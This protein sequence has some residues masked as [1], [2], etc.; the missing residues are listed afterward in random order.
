MEEY[1]IVCLTETWL[2]CNIS[3]SEIFNNNYNI[4]RKDRYEDSMN[5]GG[6]VLI[7]IKSTFS[8]KFIDLQDNSVEQI[9]VMVKI[10]YIGNIYLFLS[11][12]PPQS[13]LDIYKTHLENISDISN[14]SSQTDYIMVLGDFNLGNINWCWSEDV[15]R[16][17]A[18]GLNLECEYLLTDCLFSLNL[19]QINDIKNSIGRI[20]DLVFVSTNINV[21]ISK[22]DR[23]L[24]R[25]S[26]HHVALEVNLSVY[27]YVEENEISFRRNFRK[28]DYDGLNN[29]LNAIEW[30][31]IFP[32]EELSAIYRV[33]TDII[34]PAIDKFVPLEKI[35]RNYNVPWCN[36]H[37]KSLKNARNKAYIKY[38]NSNSETNKT[39]FFRIRKEYEF[40]NKY[41]YGQYLAHAERNIKCNSK[42]FWNFVN[43]KRKKS[44][45]PNNLKFNDESYN[46]LQ[47]IC[48]GF[49]SYFNTV[50]DEPDP[51][52]AVLE[53]NIITPNVDQSEN[54]YS[55][56]YEMNPR[57]TL[58]SQRSFIARDNTLQEVTPRVNLGNQRTF[59][60]ITP[61]DVDIALRDLDITLQAGP[62]C[63][64]NIF[65]K[66][67]KQSLSL[68]LSI[69]FNKSLCE[70]VFLDQWKESYLSPIHKKGPK[71][72]VENYR[73]IAKLS[74]IP[75]IFE[76][77]VKDKIYV[78]ISRSITP[79]QHG[80]LSGKST[81]TNLVSYTKYVMDSIE[82]GYQVDVVYTDF[83]KA[84]DKVDHNILI[85][86]LGNLGFPSNFMN[87]IHTY[88]VGR[89]QRVKINESVSRSVV[90][91]TS[92]VPQ[93]SHLGPLFFLVFIN[94]IVSRFKFARVWQY[95][96]DMKIALK[97]KNI[98]DC[99]H[100]QSDLKELEQ[101]CQ[102][103]RLNLNVGKC[104]ILSA[105]RTRT[106]LSYEYSLHSEILER[107][108]EITDLGVVFDRKFSFNSHID[109]IV[110]KASINTGFV[111]HYAR[112]FR[113]PHVYKILFTAYVRS[114][115]EYGSIVWDPYYT[116]HS[117]R[118]ERVQRRYTRFIFYQI[119]HRVKPEYNVRCALLGLQTL[120]YRRTFL[121]AMF[122]R[123]LFSSSILCDE[124]RSFFI[125]RDTSYNLRR[126]N[127]LLE[128]LH[129]T[130]YG[131][132]EPITRLIILYNCC[133]DLVNFECSSKLSFKHAYFNKFPY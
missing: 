52:R 110:S 35:T 40:L 66:H 43:S 104:K 96:D 14:K 99:I 80:F 74:A 65:L 49:A 77:I 69:I 12:I 117:D 124:I 118:L 127:L 75:K 11:Y 36:H 132:N 46:D 84:F 125:M 83:S 13:A 68:A 28:A 89:I 93:G 111:R 62:D 38:K 21:S 56:G 18:H 101:W 78:M 1:E 51:D 103:N 30:N 85:G 8:S 31:S 107:V 44:G 64:P 23:L 33:F 67:C 42:T 94:D 29:V 122:I 45:I 70:G 121:Q 27:E 86:K 3:D 55:V 76:K 34:Y 126:N 88:L 91:C 123:D 81:T 73:G 129:R 22:S 106:P 128:P 72:L 112:E 95:A 102:V 17:R 120:S 20:L 37:L 48:E 130:N 54:V 113:D 119:G 108:T 116:V 87:W 25:N 5:R 24:S 19:I 15:Y 105:Y 16:L 82:S 60:T 39:N 63:I 92:G 50:Y 97:I 26:I 7:A 100:L 59:L 47:S 32:D 9:C 6:G 4:Y 61:Q 109:Y 114:K 79:H 2:H 57:M 115:L 131:I 98:N 90:N 58:G 71:H 41:L 10:P 53:S 133:K